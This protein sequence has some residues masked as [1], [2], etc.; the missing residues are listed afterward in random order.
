MTPR[1]VIGLLWKMSEAKDGKG[2]ERTGMDW[3]GKER[4]FYMVAAN[5]GVV[6]RTICLP[7]SLD[8]QMTQ[9]SA[10]K[11]ISWSAVAVAAFRH[12]LAKHDAELRLKEQDK[13]RVALVM[14][15]GL[16]G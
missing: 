2:P 15:G 4:C 5:D 11:S 13:A 14:G 12:E 10:E 16:S 7:K 9:L 6:R 3:I 8:E 1:R